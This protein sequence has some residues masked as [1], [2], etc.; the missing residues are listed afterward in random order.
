MTA[1]QM[2]AHA[3]RDF[4]V[5]VV[6]S[7]AAGEHPAHH[8]DHVVGLE[9]HAQGRVTHAAP[10]RKGHLAVLQMVM[11]VR[12]QIMVAAMIVVQ[13]TD[14]DI[15]D[16]VRRNAE[17][18]KSVA[19]RLDDLTLPAARRRLVEAGIDDDDVRTAR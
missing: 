16:R 9:R 17:R 1:D 13:V 10:A 15:G 5:A 14:D 18:R 11:G 12:K 19:H 3:R 2:H 4:V 6:E 7:G 8:G